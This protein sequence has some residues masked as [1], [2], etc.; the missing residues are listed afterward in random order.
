MFFRYFSGSLFSFLFYI[1]TIDS[2]AYSRRKWLLF[3]IKIYLND[4][5][6]NQKSTT[7]ITDQTTFTMICLHSSRVQNHIKIPESNYVVN[8]WRWNG[9]Y[10]R[11]LYNI[12]SLRIWMFNRLVVSNVINFVGHNKNVVKHCRIPCL[13]IESEC[14]ATFFCL[15]LTFLVFCLVMNFAGK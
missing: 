4:A 6:P 13:R 7:N 1:N 12:Q 5:G 3:S 15:A 10:R 8:L 9:V 14:G 2:I 11:L